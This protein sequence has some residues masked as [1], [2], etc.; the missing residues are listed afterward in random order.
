MDI[1]RFWDKVDKRGTG[2]CWEWIAAKSRGYG[3]FT[4]KRPHQASAH[5][6]S[7]V[8]A[9]IIDSLEDQRVVRHA[10]DN[11]ACVN[12]AHLLAGSHQDNVNDREKRRRRPRKVTPKM[13]TEIRAARA[14]GESQQSI[15]D[16]LGIPQ[17]TVCWNEHNTHKADAFTAN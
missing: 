9:G 6:V 2:E 15:A 4:V 8:L 16:R 1:K 7:A 5:R 3:Y 17:R 13:V 11:P 12:P 14:R 10:C